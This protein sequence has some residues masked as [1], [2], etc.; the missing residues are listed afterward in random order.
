MSDR[1][2]IAELRRLAVATLDET[3]APG[4][5][6]GGGGPPV[7]S[8][9]IDGLLGGAAGAYCAAVNP[10]VLFGLLDELEQLETGTQEIVDSRLDSEVSTAT[11]ELQQ[12]LEQARARITELEAP[13]ADHAG[14][15]VLHGDLNRDDLE[16]VDKRVFSDLEIA[17]DRAEFGGSVYELREVTDH[18]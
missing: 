9:C 15:V 13:Q 16:L 6:Y 18:A 4:W 8:G 11:A 14:Y 5:P 17:G 1:N 3:Y 2:L 10:E 12:E 7:W